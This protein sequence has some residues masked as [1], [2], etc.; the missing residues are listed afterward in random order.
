VQGEADA[1]R[2]P[3]L[4]RLVPS[5]LSSSLGS[6][7]TVFQA[8]WFTIKELARIHKG[9][10]ISTLELTTLSFCFITFIISALWYHKPSI[11]KPQFISTK[12]NITIEE[13][14]EYARCNVG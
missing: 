12:D 10:A 5:V 7:I 8:A 2:T 4:D 13:I 1:C 14:R 6:I 11:S 9:Y 3:C